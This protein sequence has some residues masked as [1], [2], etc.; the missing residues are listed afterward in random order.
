MYEATYLALTYA[1]CATS[2]GQLW[3]AR[4]CL[5][6]LPI[7]AL[8]RQRKCNYGSKSDQFSHLV[9][10]TCRVCGKEKP[11]AAYSKS[12]IQKWYSQKKKDRDNS[13]TPQNAGLSCMEHIN[14]ERV[15]RCKG[16]CGRTKAVEYFS[17]N[18]RNNEDP[19]SKVFTFLAT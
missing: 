19:V 12:Q 15:I 14:G 7:V 9:R 11:P 3:Q 5:L 4:I 1:N 10:F 6:D 13:V 16:P 17:K 2:P 18:Q 8:C